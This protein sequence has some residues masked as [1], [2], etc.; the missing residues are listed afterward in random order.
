MIDNNNRHAKRVAG[1]V[2]KRKKPDWEPII[3]IWHWINGVSSDVG[4]FITHDV[5]GGF[6]A[7]LA[8]LEEQH[9]AL[10]RVLDIIWRIETWF[11]RT[12]WHVVYGWVHN[13]KANRM[14]AVKSLR[15]YMIRLI[16]VTTQTVLTIALRATRAEKRNREYAV[17]HAEAKL[18]AKIR[19]VHGTIERE[20]MSAYRTDDDQRK[21]L[22]VRLLDFAVLRNPALKDI[23]GTITKGVLDIFEVEDPLLRI[24]LGFLVKQVIDRLGIDKA[25]GVM[26]DDLL[27]PVLGKPKPKGLHDVIQDICERLDAL[28]EQCATFFEDGGADVEAAGKDWQRITSIAGSA[29]IVAFTAQAV[30]DP[31]AWAKEISS[32]VG[33]IANGTATRAAELFKG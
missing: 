23:V 31:S 3:G 2:D 25:I 29:A 32:T 6:R 24:A 13:E 4:H 8:E 11:D 7:I 33:A 18:L 15:R 14:R 12:I 28:E 9:K 17:R 26:I 1:M 30:V 20:A 21:T 16:Y 27:A 19:A 5:I 10:F 22:I